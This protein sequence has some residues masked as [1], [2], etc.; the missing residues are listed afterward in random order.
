MG[1]FGFV[2]VL[3]SAI[4]SPLQRIYEN[5]LWLNN[6]LLYFKAFCRSC[7]SIYYIIPKLNYIMKLSLLTTR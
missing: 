6:T 4:Y 1:H 7:V 5:E 2:I 3:S